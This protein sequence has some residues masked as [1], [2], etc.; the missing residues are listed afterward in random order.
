MGSDISRVAERFWAKVARVRTVGACW[1]WV[2]SLDGVG[3]GKFVVSVAGRKRF[4]SAH[5]VAYE[6]TYGVIP[7]GLSVLHRCDR[8]VCVNPAHLFV[9]TQ[10]ANIRDA[11][12]KGRAATGDRHWSIIHPER[13]L[14]GEAK[15]TA[16][17]TASEVVTIR[18]RYAAGGTS[19]YDLAAAYGVCRQT[20]SSIVRRQTWTHV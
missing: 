11:V 1:D 9:G 3:Y 20:I 7:A 13:R 12:A 14:R 15:G 4:L 10:R 6:L 2:A 19:T 17:L 16:K 18:A 8:P 5:R